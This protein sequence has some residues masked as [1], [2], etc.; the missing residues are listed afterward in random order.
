VPGTIQYARQALEHLPKQDS[1]WRSAAAIALG[2]AYSFGSELAAAY[3]ARLEALEASKAGGNIHLIASLKL[4][5][6]LRQQGQL[7]RVMEIC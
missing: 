3:Q 6:T 5:D 2:D 7:Q 1:N 4:A